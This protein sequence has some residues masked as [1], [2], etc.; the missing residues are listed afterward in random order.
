MACQCTKAGRI[1]KELTG[2]LRTQKQENNGYKKD[3]FDYR[4]FRVLF[5]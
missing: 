1:N 2:N 5:C 3:G 4:V